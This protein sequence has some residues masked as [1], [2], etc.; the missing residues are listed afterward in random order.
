MLVGQTGGIELLPATSE[1]ASALVATLMLIMIATAIIGLI[2]WA[3]R[4]AKRRA[5]LEAR[6][7]DLEQEH[8]EKPAS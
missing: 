8:F 3:K 4:A 1:V 2:A 7:T 6:V 5:Q